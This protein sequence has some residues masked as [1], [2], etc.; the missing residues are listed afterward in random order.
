MENKYLKYTGISTDEELTMKEQLRLLAKTFG[1]K[2]GY[3]LWQRKGGATG[4]YPLG[5]FN[6]KEQAE[7]AKEFI[8]AQVEEHNSTAYYTIE[9]L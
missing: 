2:G 3:L 6:S 1:G 4:S 7:N 8:E 9:E 5:L